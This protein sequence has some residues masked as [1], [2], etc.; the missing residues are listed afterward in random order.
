M[1]RNLKMNSRTDLRRQ[2][3]NFNGIRK[4][5]NDFYFATWNVRS[6]YRAG[7]LRNLTKELKKYNVTIAAIQ[8][9]R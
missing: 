3:C 2:Q 4:R 7:A 1:L 6:L 9:I 5:K 8:E